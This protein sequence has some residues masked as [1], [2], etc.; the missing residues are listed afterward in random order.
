LRDPEEGLLGEPELDDEAGAGCAEPAQGGCDAV[1][2]GAEGFEGLCCGRKELVLG[3]VVGGVCWQGSRTI[4]IIFGLLL[5][6]LA[7]EFGPFRKVVLG[8]G[9]C[10]F[11]V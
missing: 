3:F 11:T 1:E 10:H 2:V 7:A 5:V 9:V 4:L 8:G 6:V